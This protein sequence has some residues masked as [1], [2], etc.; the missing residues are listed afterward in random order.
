MRILVVEDDAALAAAVV[1]ALEDEV[2]T[3]DAAVSGAV[4]DEL[5]ASRD[6][7]L[8][9]LDWTIPPPTGLELLR[10]WRSAGLEVPV[11]MLTGRTASAIASAASTRAPT[12]T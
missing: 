8:V 1:E 5:M 11:L 6:Y 10:R 9:V 3:V 12:T 4:A 7:D 2:Y